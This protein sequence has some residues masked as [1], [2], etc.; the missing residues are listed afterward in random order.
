MVGRK[1]VFL[2]SHCWKYC[3]TD[4]KG[5]N[6]LWLLSK[7]FTLSRQYLV[8]DQKHSENGHGERNSK[9]PICLEHGALI[10]SSSCSPCLFCVGF[11]R[12]VSSD[13]GATFYLLGGEFFFNLFSNQLELRLITRQ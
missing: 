2:K 13:Y 9:Q 11:I 7:S 8:G 10:L 12:G 4:T 6:R 1:K 3:R 5:K